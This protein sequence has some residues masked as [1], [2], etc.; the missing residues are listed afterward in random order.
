MRHCEYFAQLRKIYLHVTNKFCIFGM[1]L[2]MYR[3]G[4]KT[5]QRTNNKP[6]KV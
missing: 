2:E 3:K 4:Y 5:A 1:I 6:Q